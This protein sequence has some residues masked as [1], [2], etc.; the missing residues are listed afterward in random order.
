MTQQGKQRTH[1]HPRP[2]LRPHHLRIPPLPGV[3]KHWR[4]PVGRAPV[5][6][7]GRTLR[8]PAAAAERHRHAA[9]GPRV[10]AHAAGRADPLPPHARLRHAVAD[11]H[12]P[13]RHR[14]RDGG[15]AQPRPR[16]PDPR[17]PRPR[18]LHRQGL[19]VARAVRPHHR[20]A[21]APPRHLRRLVA[22]RV[23]HGPDGRRR[24][25]RGVREAARAGPD[26]PRASA[27]S[28]GIRC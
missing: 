28:T 10:P 7:H 25:R 22:Q 20:T 14:H 2:Q 19:G 8:H 11:G 24:R 17:R 23:H 15:G 13:C 9:H 3:G 27:W 18:R 16:R 26:L 12:R 5:E 1:D 4:V 6:R 21:D